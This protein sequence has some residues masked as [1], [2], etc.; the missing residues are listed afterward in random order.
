MR[1]DLDPPGGMRLM[2][3]Y[4][5]RAVEVLTSGA[6]RRAFDISQE[7]PRVREKYGDGYGREVLVARRLVEAGVNFV[8]V[9]DRGTGPGSNAHNWDDH[10]VNWDLLTAMRARLPRYDHMVSTLID[11]LYD[12]GLDRKVL[13]IVTGEFGRT[14][15]LEHKDGRIGRDHYPAAMSMLFSGGGMPMGQVIGATNR[16]G[17]HPIDRKLDPNDVLATI[18][19]HLGID[20]RQEIIDTTGRPTR[21]TSGEPIAEL[22]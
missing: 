3:E 11:D 9:C 1:R 21:L 6:V 12:R 19:H 15:R 18:Y 17:E 20:H 16:R 7:S 4:N 22:V 13:L 14:P 5:R 10:A 8:T 2:D